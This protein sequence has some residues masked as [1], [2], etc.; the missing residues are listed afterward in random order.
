MPS[1][2]KTSNPARNRRRPRAALAALAAGTAIA[3]ACSGT[4]HARD[5]FKADAFANYQPNAANGEYMMNAAGCAACHAGGDDLKLL[6]GGLKMDTFIGS[7]NVPNIS[8]HSNGIGGWS[9]A[10]FLN[11]VMNGVGRDGRHLYPVMPYTSYAGMKPED[12][13]DIKAYIETLPQSDNKVAAHKLSFPYNL[14]ATVSFWKRANF[15]TP[16]FQPDDGSQMARGRYLVENVGACGECHTPRAIDFGL[17]KARAYEGEKGLTGAVAPSIAKDRIASISEGAFVKG[18]LVEGKKLS[19]APFADSVMSKIAEGTAKLSEDD[20]RAM[21]AYLRGREVEVPPPVADVAN[22]CKDTNAAA[23]LAS[24]GGDGNLAAAADQFVG[25]YCRNCHGPGESAQGSFPAGDL[26]SISTN[27]A[28]VTP[29]DR[30]RSLLYTSVANGRMPYGKRPSAAEVESLGQWIDSLDDQPQPILTALSTHAE[31]SRPIISWRD[32]TEAA[33]K[34]MSDVPERDRKFIR[35]FSFRSDYNGKLPCEADDAFA[36]RLELYK[37]GFA[38]LLNSVSL[39]AGLVNPQVVEGT[40]DLLVRV[41][42]RDL[43]WNDEKWNKL[44]ATYP[45]GYDPDSDTVLKTLTGLTDTNVPV[46]RADWFMANAPKPE[47]YHVLLELTKDIRDLEKRIGVDVDDNIKRRRVARSGVLEGVSGVS[48][49]NRMLER[50]DTPQGGYYWKSYDFAGSKGLQD[51]RRNPHGPKELE[52]LDEGLTSFHHDGGEMI[53]SLPNGL[54]GYYLS[55]DKGIQLDRGPA[56]IVSFRN[57]PIG[58]GVEIVNGRSCFDCH[59]DGIIAKRDQ[60]RDFIK[61]SPT[62]SIAQ[63]DLL[64]DMYVEQDVLAKYMAD[65]RAKFVAALDRIGATEKAPDGSL[66]SRSGPAK[67]E[68]ITWYADLYEADL[69]RDALAAE[70]DMTPEEFESALQRVTDNQ[71]LRIGLDWL[72]TLKAG[73]K[74]PRFEL[75]QQFPKMVKPLM[76]LDPLEEGASTTTADVKKDEPETP[77]YKNADYRD[78]SFKGDDAKEEK[79]KLSV[80]VKNT[81]VFVDEKL[82]FTVTANKACELQILY[83][84]SNYNVEVIPDDFLGKSTFLEASKART[85]PDASVGELVFDEPGLNETMVLFCRE[86]GLG[87]QKL[88]EAAA[89]KLADSKETGERPVR[90][91]AIKVFEKAK[92]EEKAAD[93]KAGGDAKEGGKGTSAIHMVTFNV[94]ARN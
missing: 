7:F 38:K 61:D 70:F 16:A 35:Y 3:L 19:G 31:R 69:D 32:F 43:E 94:K 12:V 18:V 17:D 30:S 75:E 33:V 66:K 39:G 86:G 82:T 64:L 54:Q 78:D 15:N 53:F 73:A 83:V 29:G 88:D 41:D 84:E 60:L 20:R 42:M 57:R 46:M 65:D 10:D 2:P 59:S 79:L 90:G 44:I 76:N 50:H 68:I 56:S 1:A 28:F 23:T 77:D 72:T 89:K 34:D 93:A 91:L 27:A 47:N 6:S 21:L 63:R 87:N 26:A 9:N 49:H 48:D 51:L 40:D 36:K 52:P 37:A 67:E 4:A 11:A 92:A 25:Q 58:K 74:V 5:L 81:D 62:F 55:T 85:V 45:F 22:A 71:V 8:A 13:L 14:S 80:D 24:A